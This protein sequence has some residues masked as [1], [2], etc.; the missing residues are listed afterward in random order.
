M[1]KF[2]L[3]RGVRWHGGSRWTEVQRAWV[4]GL[5]WGYEA[6]R[7]VVNEMV[8]AI[9]QHEA[10]L[11]SV[12]SVLV[13]VAGQPPWA[14]RVGWLRCFYGVD[15]LTAL[16]VVAELHGVERFGRARH[17]MAYL[18]L[19]PSERSSGARVR[20][21]SVTKTGNAHVRRVLIEAAWHYRQRPSVYRGLQKRR[22]GQPAW[23]IA[24]AD[25]AHQRLWRRYWR[26]IRAKKSPQVAATAVARELVGFIWA[27]L[28]AP[29]QPAHS[30]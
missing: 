1:T 22:Q 25:R 6:D 11:S 24:L 13:D 14:E 21:G 10:R 8:L 7:V 29:H 26:L 12:D 5:D 23:V 4:R 15:T 9:D 27:T 16:T 2:L 17:L 19:V 20:R 28:S 3:R 30:A 18:G